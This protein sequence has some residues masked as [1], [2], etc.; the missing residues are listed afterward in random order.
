MKEGLSIVGKRVPRWGA[1]DKATGTAKYTMDIKLPGMLVGKILT[2]PH[3]H[4]RI[5]RID[6]S[7][8]EKLPGVEAVISFEDIPQ[9]LFAPNRHDLI[10]YHAENERKDMYVI[11]EK[12]R[13]V[14]DRVAA[15]AAVDS[16]TAQ[17]ALELIEVK[18]EV[19][20]AVLDPVEAV[21]S[22]APRIHDYAENNVSL[23]LDFPLSMGDVEKG[24]REA[25]FVLEE[26]FRTNKQQIAQLEPCACA[27][28][29]GPDGRL[30]LWSP[31]QGTFLFRTKLAELFD[32]P[33]GMIQWIT[34]HVG[35]SFGKFGSLSVEP[36]CVALAKKAGKPVKIEYSREEDFSG[37]EARQTYVAT[38][39][40]GVKKD[41]T[42]T[43]L[44]E[45]LVV[46]GG[47]YFTRNS[48]TTMLNMCGFTGLYRCPSVA[49]EADCVYT[50]V[51][52]TGGIRGYGNSEATCVLEQLIDR[53][54]K[55]IGMDPIQLRLKN[56][57]R[58][59]DPDNKGL[60]MET[61]TLEELI[62]LGAEKTGWA[63]KRRREKQK[64]TKRYGIGMAIMMDLSGS[65]PA[66][67]Q[68]RNAYIKLNED[69]SANLMVMAYDMGQNMPGA[70][71]QIAAEAL[72]VRYEDIHV[73]TG[74]TDSTMFDTGS[75]G[76]AGCYQVGNAV[77]K[78]AEEAKKQLL[79]R[80]GKRL[81]LAPEELEVKDRR[82]YAKSDPR[83]GISV[84]EVARQ[85]TY[86]FEGEH[87][88]ISGKGSFSPTQSPPPFAAVFAE[89]E[90]DVETAEAK[91]LKILYVN[92]SGRVINPATVEGQVEGGIAQ[93]VGYCLTEDYVV[94]KE[95]GVLESDNFTT[96][97]IPSTLDMPETEVILYE[98]PV[99]SG[100]YGAKGV[101][102]GTLS[103]VSPAIANAIYDAVGVFIT[104]MPATPEK[105]FEALKKQRAVR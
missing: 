43:A 89:V 80:A 82:I 3:P 7:K 91:I 24:F 45:K 22:G 96:Y 37:T 46:D 10:L 56:I 59:G 55:E 98:E 74:D 71:A 84:G 97:K 30:T 69:G 41:G 17:E 11:S 48:T 60:P 27:A 51:P 21:K 73:V 38:G 28:S 18:Y 33:E 87:L 64:G 25:D 23:H 79:D 32:I 35:G 105:I 2:S 29:F 34:L 16:A 76:S 31:A 4:A 58:A 81:G 8:A 52:T 90:V 72:G 44:Q 14:G 93:S 100:P 40:I 104:D 54:A 67:I 36:V 15:V 63:E 1:Y 66:A 5:I 88:N 86:N 95:T 53:A 75:G 39:K 94:N 20:P 9:K 77:M 61:C 102:H 85:A 12:A 62:K 83:R 57:K 6:K 78:A 103:A 26:T 92:D 101:G 68:H 70:C 42:I 65:H 99:S 13:F 49:A 19:L 50:N 47:A